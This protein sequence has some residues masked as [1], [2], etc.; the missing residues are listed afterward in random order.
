MNYCSIQDAWGNNFISDQYKLYNKPKPTETFT[1]SN[2]T[3]TQTYEFNYNCDNF[4][5]HI[6]KCSNCKNKMYKIFNTNNLI[7]NNIVEKFSNTIDTNRDIIVLILIG[8][9]VMVFMN[10]INGFNDKK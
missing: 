8:I 1:N 10:L 7:P 4:F 5:E 2:K 6:K 3:Q 9:S